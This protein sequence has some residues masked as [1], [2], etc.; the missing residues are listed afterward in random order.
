MYKSAFRLLSVLFVLLYLNSCSAAATPSTPAPS[1][2]KMPSLDQTNLQLQL[3][4]KKTTENPSEKKLPQISKEKASKKQPAIKPAVELNKKAAPLSVLGGLT[5]ARF[6][7]PVAGKVSSGFGARGRRHHDGVDIPVPHGTPIQASSSGV[8]EKVK[9]INGYGKTVV[10]NH[11]NNVKTLYAHCSAFAVKEGEQVRQGQVVAYA[12]R[13]GRA[14]TSHVHFGVIFSGKF[15]DP[16]GFL[17]AT[18]IK[19][20]QR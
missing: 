6:V 4:R 8:V 9:T 17:H 11:G 3:K 19:L 15:Q 20:A 5:G 12:G 10:I 13:T 14:T 1:M 7:W 16:S 18:S 2:P